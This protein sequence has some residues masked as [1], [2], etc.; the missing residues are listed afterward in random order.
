M[1]TAT[2]CPEDNKLRLYSTSRLDQ[3]TYAR[4]KAVGFKWAPRQQL[5]VAPAWTPSREDL[6]LDLCDEIG[7]EDTSLVQR[8]EERSERFSEYSES[9]TED[10]DRAQKAVAAIADN[11]PFGQPILIGHHSERRARRDAERIRDG[12]SRAVKMWDTAKY[13]TDRAKGALQ[14]A[15]YKE[16]PDVRARRIKGLEADQRK[17]ERYIAEA[18]KFLKA[19]R[20]EGLTHE[21]A[22]SIANFDHI[23]VYYTKDKYPASTYEG[24]DS[25]WGG[26]TKGLI[27]EQ[28][29]AAISIRV[30][31]RS[32]AHAQRWL[33]HFENRIA[34]ERAM[35]A[36][37]GGTVADKNKPEKGGACRCWASPREGW[38]YIQKVNK[39]SVTV[40]QNYGNRDRNFTRT[41]PFDKLVA[42]MTAAEV[43][44]KRDAG[45]L[46]ETDDGIGFY[47]HA[48]PSTTPNNDDPEAVLRR[49]WD[50]EGVTKERQDELI[51]E[52]TA[53][54][55]P[56][57][58][59]G[60][61]TLRD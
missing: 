58:K 60:P 15:K 35:L 24:A 3:E 16:R 49:Q 61:F 45:L 19:W 32:I 20:G 28:Q 55:Q 29:A 25:V 13:W 44:A 36:E 2:Y 26:L 48:T 46:L 4:V 38:S 56:G 23:T 53:K 18:E 9:R 10:A 27:D 30:H 6:L 17:Q 51:A 37:S 14:H 8:A 57:A 43:Q 5:F 41:M 39:V 7:D 34:Y 21:G 50:A 12:M 31:E 40:L 52:V 47:L 42:V 54:A 59:V 1:M 33:A 11:I 22:L